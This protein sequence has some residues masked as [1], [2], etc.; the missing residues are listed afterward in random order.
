M[1]TEEAE[2]K[3]RESFMLARSLGATVVQLQ[4]VRAAKTLIDFARAEGVTQIVIG[5]SQRPIWKRY[6]SRTVVGEILNLAGEFGVYVVPLKQEPEDSDQ[7]VAPPSGAHPEQQVRLSD[8]ITPI[9]ILANLTGVT[10]VEQTISVLIDHLILRNADLASRR[11]EIHDLIMRRERLMS[12][13]L[14]TGIAI[15]HAAG[16]EG[17]SDIH[18]VMA[19]TPQ[20]VASLGRDQKAYAVVLFLSPE[21]GKANH[22]KFLAAIAKVFIDKTTTREIAAMP[23]AEDAWQFIHKLEL[24]GRG[25]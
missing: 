3:L 2:A 17:T 12:T 23:S 24:T 1:Q 14:D 5:A 18:A 7:P 13:F 15:P 9:Q 25:N 22:L 6:F 21:V 11:A 4:G 19:L 20:G 16:F 10:T 8:Y